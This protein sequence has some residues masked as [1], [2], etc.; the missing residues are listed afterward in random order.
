[1]K[2]SRKNTKN[3][4][5]TNYQNFEQKILYEDNIFKNENYFV[6]LTTV[7]LMYITITLL[8]NNCISLNYLSITKCQLFYIISQI[9][10]L[11]LVMSSLIYIAVYIKKQKKY[12]KFSVNQT[13]F[14]R[15]CVDSFLTILI[16]ISLV[17]K[18]IEI[19]SMQ[20]I[21]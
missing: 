5:N 10:L 2:T 8:Y 15:L 21:M 17:L 3:T 7:F 12:N 20:T 6:Y 4:K 18:I 19:F 16:L 14:I 1:M 11:L 13:I 9:V